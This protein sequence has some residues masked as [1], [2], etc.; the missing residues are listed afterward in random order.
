[1]PAIDPF[2]WLPYSRVERGAVR[3]SPNPTK[4]HQ[5]A[6]VDMH[7]RAHAGDKRRAQKE[8]SGAGSDNPLDHSASPEQGS[9]KQQDHADQQAYQFSRPVRPVAKRR[10]LLVR[11]EA[12]QLR[13]DY[14][15]PG[16]A[17]NVVTG[18]K[19][20]RVTSNVQED[21]SNPTGRRKLGDVY[22]STEKE[23]E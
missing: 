19:V 8:R 10:K 17:N 15:K 13:F 11:D 14:Q 5:E 23:A 4:M 20:R 22:K 16:A 12:F 21:A 18:G 9:R 6:G 2:L 3:A 1:M 7:L